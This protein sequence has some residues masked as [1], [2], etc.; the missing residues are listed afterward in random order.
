MEGCGLVP[1]IR[2]R[3]S[4]QQEVLLGVEPQE[5]A[6]ANVHAEHATALH[7]EFMRGGGDFTKTIF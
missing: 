1:S 4:L 7:V 5:N 6:L 2:L 3:N